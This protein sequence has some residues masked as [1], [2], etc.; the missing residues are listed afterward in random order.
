M[1]H[2]SNCRLCAAKCGI[3][4]TTDGDRAISVR[5]EADHPLS[6]GYICTKGRMLVAH[7]HDPRRI[8]HAMLGRP[9]ERVALGL[10]AVLDDLGARLRALID[11][12]GPD[13][14]GI[15]QGTVAQQEAGGAGSVLRLASAL[16]S[17]SYYTVSSLDLVARNVAGMK[18]TRG[19]HILNN[20]IDFTNARFVLM[21]GI[22][23]VVSH[24]QGTTNPVVKMRRVLERG[25]IWVVDPRRSEAASLATRHLRARPGSDAFLVAYLIRELL[26]DGADFAYLRDHAIGVDE[27]ATAVAPHTLDV[28]AARTG[29]A[30]SELLELLAA[31][32]AAGRIAVTAGTGTRMGPHPTVTEWLIYTLAIVTGS[33]DRIGGTMLTG[34]GLD[35]SPPPAGA[36]AEAPGPPSRP[37]LPSWFGQYPCAALAD[38]IEAGNLK[39]LLCFGGNPV[40]AIAESDRVRDALRSLDVFAVHDALPTQSTELAT[41]VLPGTSEFEDASLVS[42]LTPDGRRFMQYAPAVFEPSADRRAAWW[43]VREIGNRLGLHVF[44]EPLS[45]NETH[46][47]KLGVLDVAAIRAA[48]GSRIVGDVVTFDSITDDLLDGR[49]DLAPRD[50]VEQ[51]AAVTELPELALIPR[52]QPRHANWVLTDI[53][54]AAGKVDEPDL[55]IH[56]RD[57]ARAGIEDGMVVVAS[58]QHGELEVRARVTGDIA[59]GA[60]SIPHGHRSVEVNVLT[61]SRVDVD[62]ISGM[63]RLSVV[64]IS[65]RP[66]GRARA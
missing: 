21:F 14:V 23:Q 8:D 63:T 42:G 40:G 46:S 45:E 39:G 50:L 41:H 1:Q 43:Y 11:R 66:L 26:D 20:K 61:S 16:G 17:R 44:S 15:F 64:P 37:D 51:F 35:Y 55:L 60:V 19:R 34:R 62:P 59:P 48:P 3:V 6:E 29:L 13:S 10:T 27:L 32:R 2:L 36:A 57:A 30:A 54:G 49:W 56:P 25:E 18:L 28:T 5:G 47:P 4:V 65:V 7:H 24:T 22:N 38:E 33:M 9:P 31:I 53:Q 12:H 58:T 52:R